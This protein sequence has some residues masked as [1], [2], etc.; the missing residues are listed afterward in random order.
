MHIKY[1]TVSM[2][3]TKQCAEMATFMPQDG[4]LQRD[5]SMDPRV[6]SFFIQQLDIPDEE[7]QLVI[8]QQN[9]IDEMS[10]EL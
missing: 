5:W 9:A 6:A 8:P 10:N 3:S 1:V 4:S 2:N 7:L